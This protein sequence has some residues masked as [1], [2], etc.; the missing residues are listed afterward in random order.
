MEFNNDGKLRLALAVS[1][2]IA[3]TSFAA[4]F[5]SVVCEVD[6]SSARCER[7][8]HCPPLFLSPPSPLQIRWSRAK[9]HQVPDHG[10]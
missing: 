10:R 3:C 6:A 9:H 7:S 1:A 4:R 8:L 2:I 5:L